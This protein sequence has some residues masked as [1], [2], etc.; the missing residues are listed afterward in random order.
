M[1]DEPSK[2]CPGEHLI[3]HLLKLNILC[4]GI[5][6]R[7]K[8]VTGMIV[9]GQYTKIFATTS[10][11]RCHMVSEDGILWRSTVSEEWK[12]KSYSDDFVHAIMV[13]T[14]LKSEIPQNNFAA[15]RKDGAVSYGVKSRQ[16][17]MS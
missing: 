7:V 12:K 11:E 10:D 14:D 15:S 5:D 6:P 4:L 9:R 13:P 1:R 16:N 3:F 2:G 8:L 17:C